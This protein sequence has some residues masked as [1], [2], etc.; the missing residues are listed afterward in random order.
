MLTF[1]E[2]QKNHETPLE[3]AEAV[4]LLQNTLIETLMEEVKTLRAEL[5]SHTTA[6]N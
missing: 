5:Q 2:V 3:K 4:I 6:R 1:E